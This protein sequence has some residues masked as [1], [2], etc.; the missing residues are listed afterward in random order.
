MAV[1]GLC[2]LGQALACAGAEISLTLEES[3]RRALENNRSLRLLEAS[4]M[5]SD[6]GIAESQ[7]EF[8]LRLQPGGNW[9]AS[10]EGDEVGLGL[11]A[12]KKH[13]LG[14]EW[15]VGGQWGRVG[16]D[17]TSDV[18]R[19]SVQV[20]VTQPLLRRLGRLVNEEGVVQAR[21]GAKAARRDLELRRTDLV[22][23]AVEGHEEL[24]QLQRQIEFDQ[25]ALKR[26]DQLLRLTAARE[27]QGRATRVDVLRVDLQHGEAQSRLN[28]SRE[29]LA[30]ARADFAELMGLA[31]EDQVT[32]VES[33]LLDVA[34]PSLDQAVGTALSNR[35]DYAQ[36]L[37][38]CRD[39]ERGVRIA[40]RYLLPDLNLVT[41]Y[42]QSGESERASGVADHP[43]DQWF[44]GLTVDSELRSTK[45]RLAVARA[46]LTEAT[47]RQTAEIVEAALRRQ[48]QQAL[49]ALDRARLEV[50]VARRN[51]VLAGNRYR[52]ARR[53][54]E[55][56]KGD[57][58]SV[59]DA[60]SA[61]LDAQNRL[62][63]TQADVSIATYRL[64]RALGTLLESPEDLRPRALGTGA[65]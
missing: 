7:T 31:P 28:R 54:F 12:A 59:T 4:V 56:G 5:S 3:L 53:M 33:P 42:T 65:A 61:L 35:L 27:R 40:R 15:Q 24:L 18:Y 17:T 45:E 6:L 25:Q 50:Q 58:F 16:Y 39:A 32:A 55:I 36:V 60:E 22:V 30:S 43:D 47:A 63:Q 2:F 11:T 20:E 1:L 13:P 49:L 23:Q 9:S 19:A 57:N 52:L 21:S 64:L 41:R 10:D 34:S 38:D 46:R 37:D 44:V 51:L 62:L 14:T 26:A 29:R 8:A 48:V